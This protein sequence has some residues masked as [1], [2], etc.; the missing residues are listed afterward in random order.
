MRDKIHKL[1][2][3]FLTGLFLAT[4]FTWYVVYREDRHGILT[5]AFLDIGQG[6][7]I[8]IEAPNG[9]QIL[10]DAGPNKKI[11]K[12]LGRV[13]P[14]YD[15]SID[16]LALS[17]PHL[18]HFG[19]FLYVI[20]RYDIGGFVSSGTA[21][22]T[23]EF[24][25]FQKSLEQ[26][27]IKNIV[28]HRGTKVDMGDGVVLEVLFPDR[29]VTNTTPHDG[30]LVM[31][32]VY[33][34]TSI[35]LTG[36]MEENLENYLVSLNTGGLKSQVLKVGHHGSH[37]STSRTFLGYVSPTYAVISL[38]TDNS[39]GHPHKETLDI[40]NKFGVSTLR[41]DIEGTIILKSDGESLIIK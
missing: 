4:A 32:L 39:Y 11:L 41:T 14:F 22:N 8:Y 27:N 17:H 21:H 33:S 28:V 5:V 31:R 26:K 7:A 19:G 36:D 34:K 30:M 16:L 1:R 2:W 38:G 25:I 40:L 37:T 9:N 23:S 20:P 13:I 10:L 6:D 35:L 12:A 15:R 18:D 3:H 24:G 29:E